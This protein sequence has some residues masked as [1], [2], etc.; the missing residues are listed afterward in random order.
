MT[1][2]NFILQ[3]DSAGIP[4]NPVEKVRR[5]PAGRQAGRKAEKCETLGGKEQRARA[6]ASILC[7]SLLGRVCLSNKR[8]K[9]PLGAMKRC[10][11]LQ[12]KSVKT[13]HSTGGRA[14]FASVKLGQ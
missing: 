8:Y 5:G 7:E 11:Q 14:Q 4:L 2:Y 3:L 13:S 12:V 6:H 9:L 10:F 1:G